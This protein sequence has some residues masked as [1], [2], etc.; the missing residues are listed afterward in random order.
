MVCGIF[1]S[2]MQNLL[3]Q[4]VLSSCVAGLQSMWASVLAAPGLSSSEACG[5]LAPRPRIEPVASALQGR[6]L[7]TGPPGMSPCLP[8]LGFLLWSFTCDESSF[9]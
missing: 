7:T 3:L 9:G 5:I 4:R 2:H 1:L 8:M 6:F